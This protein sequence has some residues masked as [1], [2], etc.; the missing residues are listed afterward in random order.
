MA[1]GRVDKGIEELLLLGLEGALEA[2]KRFLE[3]LPYR[4]LDLFCDDRGSTCLRKSV[5]SED[6]RFRISNICRS[7]RSGA[8]LM[9]L[10][11]P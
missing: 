8:S 4:L 7:I 9:A 3:A 5:M 1:P 6:M 11:A 10:A 2:G